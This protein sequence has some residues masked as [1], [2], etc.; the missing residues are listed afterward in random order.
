M[1]VLSSG[2][3]NKKNG[4][5]ATNLADQSKRFAGAVRWLGATYWVQQVSFSLGWCL[6]WRKIEM[7]QRPKRNSPNSTCIE[8]RHYLVRLSSA[9]WFN[10][11]SNSTPAWCFR[12]E[13]IF[14]V[15]SNQQTNITIRYSPPLSHVFW[16]QIT[17]IWH[18]N[19]LSTTFSL[20]PGGIARLLP[21]SSWSF[22][23]I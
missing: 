8:V 19:Q 10:K 3:N 18:S 15:S 12:A 7:W 11:Y 17:S 9:A 21:D 6:L 13:P 23:F 14:P 16:P 4:R 5:M 20:S 1:C 2:D 22:C